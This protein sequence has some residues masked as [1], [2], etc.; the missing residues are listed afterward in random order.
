MTIRLTINQVN[1]EMERI[2]EA[3][4][5][6][7]NGGI[8]VFPTETVYGIGADAFNADACGRIFRVKERPADNP[9]MVHISRLSQLDDVASDVTDGFMSAAKILWPGMSHSYSRGTKGYPTLSLQSSTRLR[10]GCLRTR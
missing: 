5:V 9:L 4:A 8:V 6:I 2:N 10:C 1:P 3:A 7:R